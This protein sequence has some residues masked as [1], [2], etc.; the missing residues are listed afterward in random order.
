MG[1]KVLIIVHQE[2]STPGRVGE[3]L[4]DR[5]CT[6]DRRCPNLGDPLPDP[7][8]DGYQAAVI[9]G[10]PMSAND[11][12]LPG[13]RTELD[14]LE[15]ATQ[16]DR[17]LLGIC[18]GAQLIARALGARV[19]RHP[20]GLVEMGYYDIDPTPPGRSMF[21]GR[22]T[23]YQWHS[24]TFDLPDG[25]VQLARSEAFEQQAFSYEGRI[26]GLEFHPEMTRAMVERWTAPENGGPKLELPHAQ[27]REA[28]LAGFDRH[29][30]ASDAWLARFLD[31][32]LLASDLEV[33][34]PVAA[35]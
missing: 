10:G 9:F 5:G 17:P 12:K 19:G 16:G 32:H 33:P 22:Q 8:L 14:W 28:H 3:L 6:L 25:A 29:A 21:G 1:P 24:E 30:E 2:R 34:C 15:R 13:I 11:D 18:L 31:Q 4:V 23:F 26:F 27:P 20:R 35:D 7:A